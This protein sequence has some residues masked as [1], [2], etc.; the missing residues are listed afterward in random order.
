M[1]VTSK[2]TFPYLLAAFLLGC[3]RS[4]SG[5]VLAAEP[6]V[7]HDRARAAVQSGEIMALHDILARV[8]KQYE[9]RVLEVVLRDQEQGLHGWVYEIR[10]FTPNDLLLVLRVDAGTATILKIERGKAN[11]TGNV[12]D[13]KE[14]P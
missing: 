10:M 6:G 1:E 14:A 9:G 4:V 3:V 12:T 11:V 7:D 13:N 2:G 8:Y 5:D